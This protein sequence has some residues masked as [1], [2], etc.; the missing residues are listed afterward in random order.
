MKEKENRVTGAVKHGDGDEWARGYF[1]EA[2]GLPSS[3]DAYALRPSGRDKRLEHV[4]S[5]AR[6]HAPSLMPLHLIEPPAA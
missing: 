6:S 4:R 3:R 1:F 2:L 5:L